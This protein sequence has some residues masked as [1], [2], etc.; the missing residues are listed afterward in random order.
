MN[1]QNRH[2]IKRSEAFYLYIEPLIF[3]CDWLDSLLFVGI[4]LIWEGH[5]FASRINVICIWNAFITNYGRDQ[6]YSMNKSNL[7]IF[8]DQMILAYW[9][10][11]TIILLLIIV[12][13]SLYPLPQLPQM[14]EGVDKVYHFIAY[15]L[16]ALPTGY[17]YPKYFF[18]YLLFMVSLS[19]I[20]ELIQPYVNRHG[21]WLDFIANTL[22]VFLGFAIGKLSS[23]FIESRIRVS[24]KGLKSL[25]SLTLAFWKLRIFIITPSSCNILKCPVSRTISSSEFDK[26]SWTCTAWIKGSC[27][28]SWS[29]RI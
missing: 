8:I 2:F 21:E 19:G 14:G 1:Q 5:R 3:F 12:F 24:W 10:R 26:F 27:R 23:L 11:I 28:S 16:V 7:L 25:A 9:R 15:L 18:V 4:E 22:G 29:C 13:L 20:I 6:P 17:V